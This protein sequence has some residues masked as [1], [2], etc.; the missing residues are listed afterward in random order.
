[1][2]HWKLFVTL[3]VLAIL[4]FFYLVKNPLFLP[5]SSFL[6]DWSTDRGRGQKD[7]KPSRPV[8]PDVDAIL[9]KISAHG[10]ESLSPEE[11]ALLSSVSE[12]IRRRADSKKPQ[13]DLII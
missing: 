12:K 2:E 13:S 7:V 6:P 10:I 4:L 9:E 3:S 5:L 1:M 8:Q 11:K